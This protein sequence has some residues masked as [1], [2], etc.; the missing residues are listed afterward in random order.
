MELEDIYNA[1]KEYYHI[2]D[3]KKI[4]VQLATVLSKNMKGKPVWLLNVGPS[5]TGKTMLTE[6]LRYV[7]N[8][9]EPVCRKVS[10]MTEN[11]IVSGQPSDEAS[12]APQLD[13]KVMYVPDFSTIV[14]MRQEA[15][16]AIYSQFRD[17]YDGYA[18]K[19]TG[20]MLESE[21]FHVDVTF[22]GNVTNAIYQKSL[23]HQQMGTRFIFYQINDYNPD[24]VEDKALYGVDEDEIPKKIGE[25]I[26]EF[27]EYRTMNPEEF[28]ITDDMAQEIK[29]IARWTA[30]MRAGGNFDAYA[31][32]L[33]T[34]PQPEKPTR[35][36]KQFAKLVKSLKSLSDEYTDE[37]VKNVLRKIAVSSADPLKVNLYRFIAT[38]P[39]RVAQT[40]MVNELKTSKNPVKK[41]LQ[42]M[43]HVGILEKSEMGVE[44]SDGS[45]GGVAWR[46][47]EDFERIGLDWD[48]EI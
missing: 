23:I 7:E 4:D 39:K 22:I 17:L 31:G 18:R 33:K 41:R 42:E 10:Q 24:K 13:G 6:P 30:K 29:K 47:N 21:E 3:T 2:E 35:I 45:F 38:A 19:D 20:T 15:Q 36:I 11:T 46:L 44:D 34:L 16:R 37:R 25:K 28:P 43:W 1:Y 9:G 32:E 27:F 5:G 12:L 8:D 40:D 14:G 26:T 48:E